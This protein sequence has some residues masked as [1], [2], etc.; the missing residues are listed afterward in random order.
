MRSGLRHRAR[1]ALIIL[2]LCLATTAV[3]QDS[4]RV[5][6]IEIV[7]NKVATQ[8]LILGVASIDKGSPLTSATAQET[9]R[10]LYGLGMFSD[11]FLEAEQ[12]SGGL[13]V[14]INVKELQK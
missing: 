11:V 6:D 14:Y 12:I 3:A 1:T 9:I 2:V 7:G 8:S 10:R 5:V 4:Y 13:K